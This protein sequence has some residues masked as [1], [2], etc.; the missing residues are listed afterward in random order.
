MM[1]TDF[2]VAH[3]RHWDDAETLRAS[4]RWANADHLYGF[5]AE[6]GLKRLMQAF[7][8]PLDHSGSPAGQQDRVH[9]DK[10]W[11]RYDAY[12]SGRHSAPAYALPA[13]NPF[14]N[15]SADQRYA[16]QSEF[17]EI[18]VSEHRAG[19]LAI[20]EKLRLAFADGLI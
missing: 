11:E 13:Q 5:A 14:S 18:H 9:A 4:T 7:G 19:T 3:E 12:R 16:N 15:W 1:Q 17:N 10:A 20:R 6:C 2:R 8:M